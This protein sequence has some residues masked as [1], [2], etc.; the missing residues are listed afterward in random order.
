M[1]V[2]A[3]DMHGDV[4]YFKSLGKAANWLIGRYGLSYSQVSLVNAIS[5]ATKDKVSYMGYY[6]ITYDSDIT[7]LVKDW[8]VPQSILL[9]PDYKRVHVKR[10]PEYMI[11]TEGNVFNKYGRR[12]SSFVADKHVIVKLNSKAVHLGKLVAS[13]FVPNPDQ[14]IKTVVH[15]LDGNVLNNRAN[16]LVWGVC[17]ANGYKSIKTR[18]KEGDVIYYPS[19]MSLAYDVYKSTKRFDLIGLCCTFYGDI[20]KPVLHYGFY[21]EYTS[22]YEHNNIV[23]LICKT[24]PSVGVLSR[25]A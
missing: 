22:E 16:N 5:K 3:I 10:H 2:Q 18:N 24:H 21:T 7:E 25:K 6:W 19:V 4:K 14:G 11:D 13:H 8:G 23:E 1:E 20:D 17:G 15:Y 9:S 12:I